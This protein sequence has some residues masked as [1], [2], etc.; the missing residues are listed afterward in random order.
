MSKRK[1]TVRR[2]NKQLFPKPKATGKVMSV[3]LVLSLLVFVTGQ[4]TL[5]QTGE[6]A[7]LFSNSLN[8]LGDYVENPNYATT[9]L[10]M[11]GEKTVTA[12][13]TLSTDQALLDA[14]DESLRYDLLYPYYPTAEDTYG[15]PPQTYGFVEDRSSTWALQQDDDKFVVTQAR[16]TWTAAKA[17]QFYADDPSQATIYL[18]SAAVG[19]AFL[20]DMWG[21]DY[22]G[23]RTGIALWVDRD[24][25][26]GWGGGNLLVYGHAFAL[27]AAAAYYTAS[28]EQAALDFAI[29]IYNFLDDNVYDSTYGGYYITFDDTR[30]DTNVNVHVLE[31]LIEL[32]QALPTSH[33]LRSEVESRLS[34]LL[35]RFHDDAMHYEIGTDCFTYPVM[36]RDWT[37]TS[38]TI[39]FGHDL[40][41]AMLMVEAMVALGQDPLTHPYLEK[42]RDVVD[43]TFTH[44]GY[45]SDGGIYYTGTYDNGTVSITNSTLEWWPQAE[46]LGTACLMRML[47]PD[48][49]LYSDTIN[50]TWSYIESEFIDHTNHGWV[51]EAGEMDWDKADEWHANYHNGRALMNGLVWLSNDL[52]WES[53][54]P[55]EGGTADSGS[56]TTLVDDARTE[57]DD[58]WNGSWLKIITTTDGQPPQGE[59]RLV[60]DFVAATDTIYTADF[61]AVIDAGDTYMLYLVWGT[62]AN[63]YINTFHRA[64]MYGAGFL[65]SHSY[66]VGYYDASGTQGGALVSTDVVIS[67]GAGNLE[68][69]RELMGPWGDPIPTAG[70]WHAVVFDTTGDIPDTYDAA[71]SDTAYSVGDD[72]EVAASAIPEF[73][74]VITAIVS[75]TLCAGTYLWL[76][77][78]LGVM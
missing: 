52:S 68:S 70:A 74:T 29:Q 19:F 39:S 43:F 54:R 76:R 9:T 18:N 35:T 63:P 78:R 34:E 61:S 45:R 2:Y 57:A 40:E 17:S 66:K 14:F 31:A 47:F 23:G 62:A 26:N 64:Y 58:Y 8:Y 13:F 59:S 51:T 24:G 1:L 75:L 16:Y 5:A 50:L 73:P 28:G 11:D 6:A 32:Y 41:L 25:S 36:N 65:T 3:A 33:D 77:K 72:F 53:F 7:I 48:D 27:Y 10:T 60:T 20:Q 44:E 46:G 37:S 55:D 21:Y 49:P 42:I 56:T 69:H 15:D 22:G 67:D 30:K 12:E 4:V 38:Q 71:L